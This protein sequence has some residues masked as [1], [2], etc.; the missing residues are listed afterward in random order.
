MQVKE[1]QEDRRH[2]HQTLGLFSF[3]YYVGER[4]RTDAITILD[5]T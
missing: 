5:A 1:L 2:E 3:P 4:A